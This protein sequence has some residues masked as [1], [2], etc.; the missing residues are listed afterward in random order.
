MNNREDERAVVDRFL[1]EQI[2]TVPHLEALLLLWTRRPRAWFVDE[3]AKALFL[4]PEATRDIL[5]NLA[6][7]RLIVS[8]GEAGSYRYQPDQ[9]NDRHLSQVDSAYRHELVHITRL[10]HSKP[11]AAVRE[12]AKAF[13]LK[14]ERE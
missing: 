9:H 3:M 6:R 13:R 8:E 1:L 4:T 2:E 7:K 12:F 11:P 14:K 5:D 10:I